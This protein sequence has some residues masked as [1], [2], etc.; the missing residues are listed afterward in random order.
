MGTN[1]HKIGELDEPKRYNIV[2]DKEISNLELAQ[3]ISKL[4]DKELKYELQDFHNDNPAHDIHYGLNGEKLFNLGWRSPKS[5][6]E[7]LKEVIDW[8]SKNK[9]WIQ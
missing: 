3:I 1:L 5:F 9:E 8:Q 2:G 6:E 7:S 4:M